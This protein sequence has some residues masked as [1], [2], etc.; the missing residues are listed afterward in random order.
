MGFLSLRNVTK[1]HAA[2]GVEAVVAAGG[3]ISTTGVGKK[4][5]WLASGTVTVLYLT[6]SICFLAY[7]PSNIRTVSDS[8]PCIPL[9]LPDSQVGPLV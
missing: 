3:G 9:V 8:G 6:W 1:L 2:E 5:S 7:G 4:S